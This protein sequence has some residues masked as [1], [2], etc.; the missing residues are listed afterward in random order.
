L[1]F[2]RGC[3]FSCHPAGRHLHWPAFRDLPGGSPAQLV[4]SK[5]RDLERLAPALDLALR[6]EISEARRVRFTAR[7]ISAAA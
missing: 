5:I 1:L 2:V 4:A 3:A 7:H 6:P